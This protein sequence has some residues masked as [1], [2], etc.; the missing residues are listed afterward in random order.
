MNLKNVKA[1]KRIPHNHTCVNNVAVIIKPMEIT[2]YA[3]TR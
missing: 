3:Q 2:K 1:V